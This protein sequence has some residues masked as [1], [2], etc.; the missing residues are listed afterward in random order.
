MK[1][2]YIVGAS[3]DKYID[4]NKKIGDLI[5]A[6]DGGYNTLVMNNIS[7]D[8][9][10]G[11]FDSCDLENANTAKVF[12]NTQDITDMAYAAQYALNIGYEKFVLFGALGGRLSHTFANINL[13]CDL[14]KKGI[15]AKI[16]GRDTQIFA[17][18]EDKFVFDESFKGYISVFSF[19][20]SLIVSEKG[21]KYEIDSVDLSESVFKLTGVSNE[22]IGKSGYVEIKKGIGVVIIENK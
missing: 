19:D 22:F 16:V 3:P 7:P 13:I 9:I 1:T 8:I 12:K 10:V 21:L 4:I 15:F 20:K 5:I 11:D 6:A 17:L 18:N 14:S 2:C